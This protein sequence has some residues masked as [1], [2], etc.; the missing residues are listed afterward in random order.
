[1]DTAE[2]LSELQRTF[3]APSPLSY[4]RPRAV[5]LKPAGRALVGIAVL[6][7]ALSIAA[8]FALFAQ[9]QRQSRDR[10]ALLDSG[11][12][13]TG[14]VA[15]LWTSGDNK[16]RVQYQFVVDGRLYQGDARISSARRN[17]LEVGRPIAVRYVP[18]D[19]DV[20]DLGGTPRSSMPIWMPF[21]VGTTIVAAGLVCLL[22]VNYQRQLLSDGRP[23]PAIVTGI[24]R[25]HTSHGGTH[26]SMS[27]QFPMLSGI[28][29]SGRASASRK[30][31][32]VGSVI[33]IIYDPDR[34][35]RSMVYPF[36]LVRP[37]Q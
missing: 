34:P 24:K 7:F 29:A 35:S 20:N 19:P 8:T 26:R 28:I 36:G 6:L 31:A 16:R 11:V 1:M 10:Q 32:A 17:T 9:A 13:T 18:A 21:L 37:A 5:Q 33:C 22:A 23:A 2:R 27:Y 30:P 15:R 25:R 12:T 14:V 3:V 4:S